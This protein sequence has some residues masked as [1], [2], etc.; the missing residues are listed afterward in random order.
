MR[1]AVQDMFN[2]STTDWYHY[3]SCQ[4]L[5]VLFTNKPRFHESNS[6][7]TRVNPFLRMC[8]P[9]FASS[10]DVLQLHAN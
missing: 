1:D 7:I 2:T 3:S 6:K 8:V 4:A 10:K 9:M 5:P